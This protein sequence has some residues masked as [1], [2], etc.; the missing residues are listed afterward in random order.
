MNINSKWVERMNFVVAERI[1][2]VLDKQEKLYNMS[3]EC[4]SH[5]FDQAQET[6]IGRKQ[7]SIDAMSGLFIIYLILSFASTVMFCIEIIVCII[8][9][10]CPVTSQKS[11]EW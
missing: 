8:R 6:Q 5:L 11:V 2:H 1:S 4:E 3:K 9:R 7:L 10:K